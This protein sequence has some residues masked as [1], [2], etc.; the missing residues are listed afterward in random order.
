MVSKLRSDTEEPKV[1]I[2]VAHLERLGLYVVFSITV[3]TEAFF[4]N[5]FRTHERKVTFSV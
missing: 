4:H 5:M 2:T 1:A 3:F